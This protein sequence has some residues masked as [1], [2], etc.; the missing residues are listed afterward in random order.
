MTEPITYSKDQ[1]PHLLS[2]MGKLFDVVRL[3][4]PIS[5]VVYTM[6]DGELV[7]QPNGCFHVWNKTG[8]CENCIS[9]K[10]FVSGERLSKFEFIDQ[11]IFHVVSQ[12]VM[13][14]NEKYVLEV[15]TSSD[16]EVLVTAFGNSDFVDKIT[17]FNHKIYT[18]ELTGVSNRRYLDERLPILVDRAQSADLS[19]AA[20]MVDIDDFKDVNDTCGHLAGD[21]VLK[22]VASVI[23]ACLAPVGDDIVARYGGD[24]FFAALHNVSKDV[25]NQRMDKIQNMIA[26]DERTPKVSIGVFYQPKIA[27]IDPIDLV[28]RADKAMYSVKERGKNGHVIVE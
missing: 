15:V 22:F 13:I 25:L 27:V 26:Q 9:S 1:V 16:D 6:A 18:D 23:A 7:A 8:R 5:M 10:C 3:V 24:E 12:P 28:Q 20:I 19:L 2:S 11:D 17:G 4:D 21:E 14:E